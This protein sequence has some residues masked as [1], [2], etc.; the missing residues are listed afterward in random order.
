[1]ELPSP[2]PQGSGILRASPDP[3][4]TSGPPHPEIRQPGLTYRAWEEMYAAEGS[5]WFWWYGDDQT[6]PGG[7]KPFDTAYLTHLENIYALRAEGRVAC[8]VPGI[9]ADHHGRASRAPQTQGVMAKSAAGEVSVL[10]TCDARDVRVTG[11]VFIAGNLPQLGNW[12]PNVV[13]HV[14]RRTRGG[15]GGGRRHLVAPGHACRRGWKCSTSIRTAATRGNGRP[16]KSS[17]CA[18]GQSWYRALRRRSGSSKTYSAGNISWKTSTQPVA[19]GVI[20]DALKRVTESAR[21]KNFTLL[22]PGALGLARRRGEIRQR[23]PV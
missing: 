13:R 12:K 23:R 14:G 20:E 3:I 17:P 18:T 15:L 10:F 11:A 1:M 19:L 8:P 22:R 7:D 6:A 2:G 4:R 5:D 9:C 16:A 21:R